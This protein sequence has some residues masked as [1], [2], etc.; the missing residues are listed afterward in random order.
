[1][2]WTALVALFIGMTVWQSPASGAGH[3]N[4]HQ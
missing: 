2:R 4:E 3:Q 1:M